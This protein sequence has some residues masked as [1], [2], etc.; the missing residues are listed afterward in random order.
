MIT[1]HRKNCQKQIDGLMLCNPKWLQFPFPSIKVVPLGQ[2]ETETN[3]VS[4]VCDR[5]H[6]AFD[7][8][9]RY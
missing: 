3:L 6:L 1:D 9:W 4:S 7:E 5:E 8:L 2:D